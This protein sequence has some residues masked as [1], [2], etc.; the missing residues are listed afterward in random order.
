MTATYD[1]L[2]TTTLGSNTSVVS[3]TGFA[4]SYTDLVIIGNVG[5]TVNTERCYF[6]FNGDTSSSYNGGN[7]FVNQAGTVDSNY[8]GGVRGWFFNTISAATN[9]VG[10]M[11]IMNIMGY[12]NTSTRKPVLIRQQQTAQQ[13]LEGVAMEIATW[14][15]NSAITSIDLYPQSGLWYAGSSFTLYGIKAE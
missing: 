3:F 11:F 4:S 7:F 2:G 9:V 13:T 5:I 6:I 12:S 1:S 14:R 15:S 8:D 10:S